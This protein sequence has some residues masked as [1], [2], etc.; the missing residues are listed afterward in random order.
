M[1][2]RRLK[3]LVVIIALVF[4]IQCPWQ[5]LK[6]GDHEKATA[7]AD[8]SRASAADVRRGFLH[9]WQGYKDHARGHDSLKPLS[10]SYSDW[11][12][13]PL[14]MTPVDALDTMII[15]GLDDEAKEAKKL[16]LGNL[17]FDKDMKVQHFEITI[18]VLGGLISA[19]QL[20]GDKRLLELA[21]DLA[22]RMLPV[23]DSPTGMP[24]RYVNL[25]TGKT[26]GRVSSPAEIGTCLVEYGALSKLTGNPVYYKK[27]KKAV[28]ALYEER[29]RLGLVG[30]AIDVETGFWLIR[31]A[32]VGGG[33]DSYYE[34]LLK[35]WHLFGDRDCKAM[36]EDSINAINEHLADESNG[37]LWYGH[38]GMSTGIRTGTV[39]GA[40]YAFFP[41]VLALDGDLERA[42][43]LQESSHRMW[44]LHGIEPEALDYR[45]MKVIYGAYP[46][47]PEIIESAYY[48]YYYTSEDKYRRMGYVYWNSIEEHCKTEAGYAGISDVRTMKKRDAMESYFLAETM[49][50]FYLLFAPPDT[51]DL[52]KTV[53]NT[54]A[55][56]VT[57]TW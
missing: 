14:L 2:K 45:R 24:Y 27:A 22:D 1:I 41:G 32:H 17:S 20:D 33:I 44:T 11:Y 7:K 25:K 3:S 50:Y 51:L 6:K 49:K 39:F 52:E 26:S 48:L 15:M 56:P 10:K 53:F 16:I 46:L 13:E 55:H 31:D 57:R 9:A 29:S 38:A 43:R 8:D 47:R 23:F 28:T 36:W 54:E 30:T 18:R 19:Y 12:E 21:V 35:C 5:R 34:Y 37:R 40:L 42:A 4:C